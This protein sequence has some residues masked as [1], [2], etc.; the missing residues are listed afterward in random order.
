VLHEYNVLLT[1]QTK[2]VP[3]V[4][5][6]D[7]VAIKQ[8]SPRFTRIIA[9]YGFQETPNITQI[10]AL[11][12]EQGIELST[13]ETSFFLSRDSITV[14]EKTAPGHMARLRTGFFKWL[15]KNS[16]APTDYYRIPG[17]RVVELGAQV[18]L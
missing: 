14:A 12:A 4:A 7:R 17:N 18:S 5:N 8:L 9:N 6:I 11:V 2:D 10:L 13:M 16:T 1:I 15:Y 3:H